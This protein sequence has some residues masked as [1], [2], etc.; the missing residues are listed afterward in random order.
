M[1]GEP[2]GEIERGLPG[3]QGEY[4]ISLPWIARLVLTMAV[5]A[6]V[7]L[8]AAVAFAPLL[9][10]HAPRW[11]MVASGALAATVL[12]L[13]KFHGWH[14]STFVDGTL[15]G[16]SASPIFAVVTSVHIALSW[17][18]QFTFANVAWHGFLAL[19]MSFVGALV[20]IPCGWCAGFAY[21]LLLSV[22]ERRRIEKDDPDSA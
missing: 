14:L 4:E 17:H 6:A 5:G 13:R 21:H 11:S 18:A 8:L 2:Q 9:G 20:T 10:S 3:N 16:V 1:T 12:S 22:A 7:G 15:A 19:V